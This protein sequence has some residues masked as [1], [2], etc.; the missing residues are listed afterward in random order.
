MAEDA[1]YVRRRRNTHDAFDFPRDFEPRTDGHHRRGSLCDRHCTINIQT[2]LVDTH[3]GSH[4]HSLLTPRLLPVLTSLGASS[5]P[6]CPHHSEEVQNCDSCL[7]KTTITAE[8]EVEALKLSNNYKFGFKKWKSHV[9][10]RPWEDR[11][12]IVKELYSDL[13]TVKSSSESLISFG[14]VLYVLLFGWWVTIFYLLVSI[15]MFLT[16]VGAPYGVLCWRLAGYFIWPFGKVILKSGH[17]H[18][19]K[20]WVRFS[21]CEAIPEVEESEKSPLIQKCDSQADFQDPTVN[22]W[23]R[24]STYL[25]LLIGFPLLAIIHGLASFMSW[26]LVFFIPI[27]KMNARTLYK[28]LLMPPENVHIRPSSKVEVSYETEIILC[29]YHAINIYYYKYTVDGLNVFAVNL[30]LLVIV[31]LVL[32]YVDSHNNYTSSPVKFTLSLLSIMPLSYYIGMAIASISAQSNFAVGAVVNATFGSIIE[33]TFYIT[34]LIKGARENDKCYEEVVKSAL[35]GTLLGCVLF[36]PG[37][38]MVIGGIKHQEQRFNSRSAGVGSALLFI[39]VGGVFAPTLF[40]KV[41]G[42][43]VCAQCLNIAQN[44]SEKFICH[45]CEN[46]IMGANSTAFYSEVQPLVYTVSILLPVAYIIGLIFTLKTHSHIYDIHISDCHVPGHHHSAVVHWSRWRAMV[47]LIVSTLLM[48]ACADLAT[49][50]ISP[51][52][53]GATVSQYFIGV[54]V[55]AMIPELPEIVNGIQFALLNNLSLS[56]EIGSCIAV[57]VCMLQIPILVL[58]S[59]FYPSGFTLIFSD[60]HLWACMFSVILMNYIF[61]DGK[62]DYF[63]GTVLVIVYFILL[64]MYFFA[65]SPAGC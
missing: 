42:K 32:G 47:I 3:S 59:I 18:T 41:Y 38:C 1:D 9:T 40:S 39:S 60:L 51:I 13:N 43:M 64:A 8:N 34:A 12:E 24:L 14:N 33:L 35:T 19:R 53:K 2:D 15:M 11:S 36:V 46:E 20:C 55:L 45:N 50:H 54:T 28:V 27:S 29:C 37:L 17:A 30:I 6:C 22:Y 26:I 65:P 52:L 23:W 62:C 48:S 21:K 7:V 10:E 57:Q 56:I 25:W 58:F 5:T 4:Q 44:G 31:S 16:I 63:Q 49:E 61:M